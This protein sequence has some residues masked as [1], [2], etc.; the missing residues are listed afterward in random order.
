MEK[1]RKEELLKTFRKQWNE[2][3][4]TKPFIIGFHGPVG[5]GKNTSATFFRDL[6]SMDHGPV[7][8]ELAFATHLKK[9]VQAVYGV[10]EHELTDRVLKNKVIERYGM[11]PRQMCQQFGTEY[12]REKLSKDHWIRRLEDDLNAFKFLDILLITDARFPNEADWIHSKGGI[13]VL[14]DR[15][16]NK[17][18]VDGH[19]SSI[20][21]PEDKIDYILK[22]HGD[23]QDLL[24][25]VLKLR[26]FVDAC[27]NTNKKQRDDIS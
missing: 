27:T 2:L 3:E 10:T 13:V 16:D 8:E 14:I 1:A 23:L 19:S 24:D 5:S 22:N 6:Y 20:P 7:V 4:K 25:E 15:P 11:S 18:E 17:E 12:G 9:A 21:L 26:T